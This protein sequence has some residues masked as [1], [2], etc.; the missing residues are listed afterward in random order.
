MRYLIP[1]ILLT[2]LFPLTAWLM[3]KSKVISFDKCEAKIDFVI[4]ESDGKMDA[5][6]KQIISMHSGLGFSREFGTI[7]WNGKKYN[8]DRTVRFTYERTDMDDTYKFMIKR[9]VSSMN[10][11]TPETLYFKLWPENPDGVNFWEVKQ[12]GED[13]YSFSASQHVFDICMTG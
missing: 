7:E 6:I 12:I 1:T 5:N 8:L 9:P 2:I 13:L 4:H 11:N 3:N 10:D